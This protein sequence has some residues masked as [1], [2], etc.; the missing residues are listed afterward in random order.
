MTGVLDTILPPH[1]LIT[2]KPRTE[3]ESRLWQALRFIDAPQCEA[4]GFPFEFDP[5]KGILCA[6][7]HANLPRYD[8]ARSAITYSDQSRKLVLDFKYGGRMDGLSFS[9]RKC[10]ASDGNCWRMR[11]FL[12]LSLCIVHA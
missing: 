4:C 8:R 2:G 7:C 1:S 5:G 11:I 10:S 6:R 9:L 12:F 3:E